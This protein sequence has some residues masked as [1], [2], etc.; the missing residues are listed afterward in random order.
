MGEVAGSLGCAGRDEVGFKI[1]SLTSR[2]DSLG[3]SVCQSNLSAMNTRIPRAHDGLDQIGELVGGELIAFDVGYEFSLAIDD[4]RV[5]RV[6]HQAFI[7]EVIDSEQIRDA[8]NI[9]NRPSK[10]MPGGRIRFPVLSI[11]GQFLRP[12]SLR[13]KCHC[14]QDEITAELLLESALQDAEIVGNSIAKI[15][16]GTTRVD[17][18]EGDYLAGVLGQRDAPMRLIR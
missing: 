9:R 3:L 18:V 11:V 15:R 6:I 8:L 4:G 17:E 14:Q 13:V 10:K 1:P 2:D 16:Q 12:V 7:G 5:Q